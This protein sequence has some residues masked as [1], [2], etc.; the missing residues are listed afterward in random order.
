[1]PPKRKRTSLSSPEKQKSSPAV[2]QSHAP[3]NASPT[4]RTSILSFLTKSRSNT[5]EENRPELA[6]R[7][8]IPNGYTII[9]S[10]RQTEC[11]SADIDCAAA[12]LNEAAED[13]PVEDVTCPLCNECLSS[14]TD[15]ES[16]RH[17]NACLDGPQGQSLSD[18]SQPIQPDTAQNIRAEPTAASGNGIGVSARS[19]SSDS[20]AA[21]STAAP[22]TAWRNMF[23]GNPRTAVENVT[24]RTKNAFSAI[25]SGN[26]EE[27]RW[28]A[29]EISDN[30]RGRV[31]REAPFYKILEGLPWAVDG[32]RYGAIPGIKHYVLTHFHSDHYGG[33]SGT[34]DWGP[35]YC[36]EITAALV[37][38]QLHV[39]PD[40]VIA[41][42]M[43]KR[44]VIDGVAMTLIDANHCP[45]AAIWLFEAKLANGRNV[46]YLHTGDFRAH[47]KHVLHPALVQPQNPPID[48]LYLDT[49]Y[50]NPKYQ[51]PAQEVV[52]QACAE[53]VRIRMKKARGE[54]VA[55][56][57]TEV[58]TGTEAED[59]QTE[60]GDEDFD[61]LPEEQME[62]SQAEW[63]FDEP[64]EAGPGEETEVK[65]K[66][67]PEDGCIK[68]QPAP[69]WQLPN[70]VPAEVNT[71]ADITESPPVKEEPLPEWQMKED[72]PMLPPD[73]K[74]LKSWFAPET[75]SNSVVKKD[76]PPQ[77]VLVIIG[78]YSI[79]KEKI[80]L[81][82]AR[83]I[84]SKIFVSDRKQRIYECLKYPELQERLTNNPLEASIHVVMLG[85]INVEAID[86]YLQKLK[87][88]F[89]HA[90]AF[91]PT[92]WT[93][94]PPN[95]A[96][97]LPAVSRIVSASSRRT[98]TISNLRL[99]RDSN[100]TVQCYGVPYSEHSSFRELT[101]FV[102][103]LGI[104][105]II[106]TVNVGSKR[107]RDKMKGWFERWQK[108]KHG[109][110]VEV[111]D[112]PSEDY[113]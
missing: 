19:E 37:I 103:S 51:F 105:R 54:E 75:P 24:E 38:Q 60:Y 36:S 113:W 112:Y 11:L 57:K 108:A 9:K 66:Q 5:G 49:T 8:K 61:E 98:Y 79:G 55:E 92:G 53:M 94:R 106:P 82:I 71:G 52:I 83:A 59:A 56:V 111:V 50:L 15:I 14:L 90:V 20:T 104:R 89:T 7:I 69:E 86:D 64:N 91:R 102:V 67:E 6:Q 76:R 47:P 45:G 84:D 44:V 23:N 58:E 80:V 97:T 110:R 4:E 95:G 77:R 107:S 18:I 81:G 93:Y 39:R 96:D 85:G 40:Y 35:I 34:W 65:V 101:C 1:M 46:R 109:K 26:A 72:D 99:T 29:A 2:L 17:V 70:D 62:L 10:Q 42:P 13:L 88:H 28:Q 30:A 68:P 22:M 27:K 31:K 43:N 73:S 3:P 100:S 12:S 25:M 78:T 33:L 32:F 63:Q 74:S 87:P 21:A 16:Q 41:L 48:I